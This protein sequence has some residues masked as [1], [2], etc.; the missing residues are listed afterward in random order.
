MY[1]GY[2]NTTGSSNTF[3]GLDSGRYLSDG[4]SPNQITSASIY[5][6]DFTK[7]SA[8]GVSNEIVIGY[9]SVGAGSN[10]VVLGNTSVTA[11]TLRGVV[12]VGTGVASPYFAGTAANQA[13]A[14]IY[15]QA[16][17][18]AHNWRNAANGADLGWTVNASDVMTTAA[19]LATTN[20]QIRITTTKTPASAADT[21]TTGS[22]AWD[23]SFLYVCTATNTWKRVGIATW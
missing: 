5:L 1:S 18:T 19:I 4:V 3:L 7:A 23:A 17:N 12:T 10:S 22:I 16:N 20:D 9:N 21:G 2:N 8:N 14:G 15:R 11:T 13:G 6:G